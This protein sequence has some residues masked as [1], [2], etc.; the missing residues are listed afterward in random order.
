[1]ARN[2]ADG[3]RCGGSSARLYAVRQALARERAEAPLLE[4][5]L[6]A[7]PPELQGERI[8]A[9]PCFRSW[10]LCERLLE[11]SAARGEA[12]RPESARLA[13]LALAVA[14]RLVDS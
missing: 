3:R 13:D 8:A 6:A 7:H 2:D 5:R 4:S 14:E 11:R 1:M 10:G 9:D 12:D